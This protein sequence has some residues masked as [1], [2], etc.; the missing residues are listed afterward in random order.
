MKSRSLLA[1]TQTAYGFCRSIYGENAA[2]L[3]ERTNETA[4]I[5]ANKCIEL[6]K[7]LDIPCVNLW[8]KMQETEGWHKFLRFVTSEATLFLGF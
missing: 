7:K 2:E 6:A 1:R 8:S 3:A 4:G 5:Y